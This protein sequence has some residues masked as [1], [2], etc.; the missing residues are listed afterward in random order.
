MLGAIHAWLVQQRRV[1]DISVGI[2]MLVFGSGAAFYSGVQA[3]AV[4]SFVL[5]EES[6]CAPTPP[7]YAA[8]SSPFT[9]EGK[10]QFDNSLSAFK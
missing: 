4:H 1:N 5:F 10:G 6:L 9:S 2:A 7:I 3:Y 8:V